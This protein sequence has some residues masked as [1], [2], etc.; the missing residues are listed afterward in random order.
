MSAPNVALA[1]ARARRLIAANLEAVAGNSKHV[2][3]LPAD[4]VGWLFGLQKDFTFC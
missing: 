2:V 1:T 4:L 3:L